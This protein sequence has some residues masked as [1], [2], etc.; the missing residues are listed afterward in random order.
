VQGA[1]PAPAV[2]GHGIRTDSETFLGG[3]GRG[4]WRTDSA[5]NLLS[6]TFDSCKLFVYIWLLGAS[7]PDPTGAPLL[8]PADFRSWLRHWWSDG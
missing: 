3:R 1:H 6:K 7:L 4:R 8:D 5:T 2:L